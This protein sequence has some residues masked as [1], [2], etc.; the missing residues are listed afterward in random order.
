M[1][2]LVPISIRRQ[3]APGEAECAFDLVFG[4]VHGS[5]DVA[6]GV[7]LR[8]AGRAVRDGHQFFERDHDGLGIKA[9]NG[10]IERTGNGLGLVA[11]DDRA[12]L[13]KGGQRLF[14]NLL[15]LFEA[16]R[17]VADGNFGRFAECNNQGDRLGAGAEAAL[18]ATAEEQ[19]SEG[20]TVKTTAP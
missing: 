9:R 5:E 18:L 3:M 2:K 19:R 7:A 11:G 20:R 14:L 16:L 17:V 6:G 10:Y 4:Q 15:T 8:G 1:L 13:L 12:Q